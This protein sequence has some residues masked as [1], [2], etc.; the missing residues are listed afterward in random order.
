MILIKYHSDLG[1][2]VK[3]PHYG[4]SSLMGRDHERYQAMLRRALR[5]QEL[6]GQ[7]DLICVEPGRHSHC[8]TQDVIRGYLSSLMILPDLLKPTFERIKTIY[9]IAG[10]SECGKSTAAD[11]IHRAYA[12]AEHD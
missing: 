7:Y 11:M 12:G 4:K 8:Q 1:D 9:A 5:M 3:T 10:L 6:A 2:A